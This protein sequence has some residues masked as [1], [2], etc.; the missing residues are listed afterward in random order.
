MPTLRGGPTRLP[1]RD[2]SDSLLDVR[3]AAA[4][5]NVSETWVRRHVAEL[6]VV[7]VGRLVRFDAHLLR[8]RF[9]GRKIAGNR[10]RTERILL[11]PPS[12]Y[13]M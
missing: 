1:S 3:A 12:C 9:E 11:W 7:R 8:R 13:Q 5:L 4:L 6:P 10:L 2:K